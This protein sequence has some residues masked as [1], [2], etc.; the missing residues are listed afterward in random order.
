MAESRL[1]DALARVTDTCENGA[2]EAPPDPNRSASPVADGVPGP[3]GVTR[4]P[5]KVALEPMPAGFRSPSPSELREI[6]F[7]GR[8]APAGMAIAN[9]G[10]VYG[11]LLKVC[12]DQTP[13]VVV[14]KLWAVLDRSFTRLLEGPG[15]WRNKKTGTV[16]GDVEPENWKKTAQGKFLPVDVD[17]KESG[18]VSA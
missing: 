10:L 17:V 8:G 2:A 11:Q 6:F 9:S 1:A 3:S 14:D 13:A 4:A 18:N 7:R 16:I 5:A 12:R 15:E